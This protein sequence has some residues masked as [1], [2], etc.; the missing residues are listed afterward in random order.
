MA[1]IFVA[2]DDCI[3]N[4]DHMFRE[5]GRCLLLKLKTHHYQQTVSGTQ[6]FQTKHDVLNVEILD[7]G[8]TYFSGFLLFHLL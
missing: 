2:V 3:M 8:S 1:V 4:S 7:I 5:D 6:I